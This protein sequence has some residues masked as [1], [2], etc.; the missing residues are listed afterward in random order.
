MSTESLGAGGRLELVVSSQSLS[1][2]GR[3]AAHEQVVLIHDFCLGQTAI[4]MEGE[5]NKYKPRTCVSTQRLLLVTEVCGYFVLILCVV[6][7]LYV[8]YYLNLC[9]PVRTI[10]KMSFLNLNNSIHTTTYP[11]FLSTL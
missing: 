2:V 9:R 4:L 7:I 1:E 5:Q 10:I 3:L 6:G 8:L 11:N